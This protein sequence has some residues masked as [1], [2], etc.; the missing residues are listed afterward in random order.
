MQSPE[1]WPRHRRLATLAGVLIVLLIAAFYFWF[2]RDPPDG[3]S[4]PQVLPA[5]FL[6]LPAASC[7]L[8]TAIPPGFRWREGRSDPCPSREI[9]AGTRGPRQN[10]QTPWVW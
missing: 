2:F 8:F 7:Q 9:G 6:K 4:R 10:G 3:G 5:A 1:P